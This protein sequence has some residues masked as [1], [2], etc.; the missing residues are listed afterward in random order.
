[1]VPGKSEDE[2]GQRGH[3]SKNIPFQGVKNEAGEEG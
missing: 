1:M 2:L 3:D